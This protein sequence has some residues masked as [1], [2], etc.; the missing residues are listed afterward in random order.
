M[1]PKRK[2]GR[3]KEDLLYRFWRKYDEADSL[4]RQNLLAPII[5][6]FEGI[7]AIKEKKLRTHVLHSF[8][9][10]YFDNLLEYMHCRKEETTPSIIIHSWRQNEAQ[11]KLINYFIV[12][13]QRIVVG[14][15]QR[16][17]VRQLAAG[18]HLP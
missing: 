11:R 7:C 9:Q 1:K 15:A 17:P 6:N 3:I 8:L 4:K 16:H 13:L 5:K 18:N 10:S 2:A 14:K 12:Q